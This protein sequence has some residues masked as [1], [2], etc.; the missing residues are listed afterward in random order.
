MNNFQIGDIVLDIE[1]EQSDVPL[2]GVITSIRGKDYPRLRTY[3][4]D[5]FVDENDKTKA[6][7]THYMYEDEIKKVA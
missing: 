6:S 5:W 4:V 7:Y 2:F 1:G 3:C